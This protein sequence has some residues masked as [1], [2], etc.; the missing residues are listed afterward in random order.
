M[1]SSLIRPVFRFCHQSG[2]HGIFADILPFLRITFSIA[3]PMMK[4]AALKG[5]GVGTS[6][7]KLIFPKRNPTFGCE[8][9]IARR[10]KKMQMIRHQQII[11]D[12]PSRRAVKP[13]IVQSVLDGNLPEPRRTIF[14]ANSQ[15]NPI[16]SA[17]RNMNTFG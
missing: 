4:S 6:F 16:R 14:G 5:S 17:K 3:E 15:K 2:A 10:T 11:A 12:Q 8:M 13:E 9:Q 7:G 1:H